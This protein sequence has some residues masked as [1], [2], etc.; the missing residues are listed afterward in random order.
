MLLYTEYYCDDEI[1]NKIEIKSDF[2]QKGD[3]K[4]V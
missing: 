1:T 3:E 2:V 4:D